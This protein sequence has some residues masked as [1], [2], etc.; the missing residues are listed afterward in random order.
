MASSFNLVHAAGNM[1]DR[2]I[3]RHA[4][5]AEACRHGDVVT[6]SEVIK[7]HAWLADH[8]P[9]GFE[10]F[11]VGELSILWRGARFQALEHGHAQVMQGGRRGDGVHPHDRRRRGPSRLVIWVLLRDRHT[12]DLVLVYTHH[13]IAKPDSTE[14]WRL[15]LSRQG[16]TRTALEVIAGAHR[17]PGVPQL[18]TGDLNRTGRLF[19]FARAGLREI[20]TPATFGHRRYDRL[21]AGP[22]ALVGR[23]RRIHTAGDHRA[24]WAVVTLAAPPHVTREDHGA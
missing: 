13:A 23:V 9:A 5:V 4:I 17:H 10:V 22:G 15:R 12:G 14:R 3:D 20:P 24:L 7:D 19:A 1:F 2:A 8:R 6:L 11:T 18:L 16:M 21:F